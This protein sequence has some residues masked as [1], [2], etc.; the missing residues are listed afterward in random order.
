MR[1]AI[2]LWRGGITEW[3]L[4]RRN[5]RHGV[6][7][8]L[9]CLAGCAQSPP[10]MGSTTAAAE[11]AGFAAKSF[12]AGDFRLFAL[13]K[14]AFNGGPVLTVYI[15]GDG[16]AWRRR[17]QPSADPTPRRS[18]PLALAIQ[19]PGP[20]VL[21]LARPCQF[22]PQPIPPE[23]DVRLWTSHRY[24]APVITAMNAAV[25]EAAAGFEKVALVG[26][27]GGGTVAAL[28]AARRSDVAF[29]VT[30]AANLDHALWTE[31]HQV[32]ALTGSLN[33][34]DIAADV[35]DIPQ[36]HYVGGRDDIVPSRVVESFAARM[37][38]RSQTRIRIEPAFDH[39]CCW[40]EAWP[41]LVREATKIE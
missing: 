31:L 29:M 7:S 36:V 34:A 18:V 6:S 35:Q 3:F 40:A 14:T 27:S 32:I 9:L 39:E 30:A 41:R 2:V 33:A 17:N 4:A 1:A 37:T 11:A 8:V 28:I 25:T 20:A 26:Y 15:E 21:Y 12:N 22:Q 38:D 10:D 19:D 5:L 24:S 23:C 16:R 13:Q